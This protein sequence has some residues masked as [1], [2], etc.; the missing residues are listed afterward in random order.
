MLRGSPL[1]QVRWVKVLPHLNDT[2]LLASAILLATQWGWAALQLPWLLAK[3]VAL[4]VYI[5]LGVVALHAG[6][7]RS[8]RVSAGLAALLVFAYIVGVAVSKNPWLFF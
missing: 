2:L 6:H 5:A 8:V 7:S 1:L 4:L 3:I